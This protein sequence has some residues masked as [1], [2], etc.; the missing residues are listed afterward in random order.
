MTSTVP[1]RG[2]RGTSV[3]LLLALVLTLTPVLFR[4]TTASAAT[5]T[6]GAASMQDYWDGRANWVYQRK[7]SD[8]DTGQ[9]ETY[10]GAH[11]TIVGRTWYLFD[12]VNYVGRSNCAFNAPGTFNGKPIGIQVRS[13]INQGATWSAPTNIITPDAG[14]PWSCYATDGDAYYN[15]AEGTNGTWHYLFQCLPNTSPP[16]PWRGC[17]V[18]RSG[19]SPMGAFTTPAGATN[20]VINS[21]DIW[22]Q[23]CKAARTNDFCVKDATGSVSQEGTFQ[24]IKFDGTYY[25]VGFHG[26]DA[27]SPIKGFRGIA[28]TKDFVTFVS[29]NSDGLHDTPTDAALSAADA[30]STAAG[31]TGAARAWHEDLINGAQGAGDAA[32]IQEGNYYYQMTEEPDANFAGQAGQNWDY[33]I[34]R[35]SSLT[36]TST[37]WEPFPRGNPIEFSSTTTEIGQSAPLYLGLQYQRIFKDPA[38]GFTYLTFGRYTTDNNYSALYFYRL[39]KSTN[40]LANG[41]FGRADAWPWQVSPALS[42]STVM[43]VRRD[44]NG[45][46]NGGQYLDL[47]CASSCVAGQGIYQDVD[48]S[49][50]AGQRRMFTGKATIAT[51]SGTAFPTV[52]AT[53]YDASGA[54]VGTTSAATMSATTSYTTRNL[55]GKLAAT[56]TRVRFAV[57]VDPSSNKSYRLADLSLAI[58]GGVSTNWPGADPGNIARYARVSAS[59]S[60]S[61][62]FLP[63]NAR[64]G[65]FG[66]PNQNEWASGRHDRRPWIKYT[67]TAPQIV[68]SALIVDRSGAANANGG[69]LTFS[70]GSTVAVS[71]I[72]PNGTPL[73]VHF[74][75]RATTSVTFQVV[76]GSGPDVGLAELEV[77][78]APSS[79]M[80]D[81]NLAQSTSSVTA[82]S[83]YSSAFQ[84]GNVT[85]GRAYI[86]NIGEWASLGERNP[87]ITLH[88]AT[89]IAVN[90]VRLFDRS[91]DDNANGG[92]LTF[93]NGRT[94]T[95]VSVSGIPANGQPRDVTFPEKAG[96]TTIKFQVAGGS[97]PNVGLAEM[98]V[99]DGPMAR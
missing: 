88:W 80:G 46:P 70:D 63:T 52:T 68:T 21:G 28:K 42:G 17:T 49:A 3:L 60:L 38:T 76:D 10:T 30:P 20:P 73:T 25:W 22:S 43:T 51:D 32:V 79:Q 89:P 26:V 85:D 66:V 40:L 8:T 82:S 61:P 59:S 19:A 4:S 29:G 44:P 96:I 14:T 64:D 5:G 92:T 90:E 41:D 84:P 98:S 86:G 94:S 50:F 12:R 24:I 87:W 56:T 31:Q 72:P 55:S 39:E 6:G 99:W 35:A 71:N 36:A 83:Q 91:G 69:R 77:H 9:S 1:A 54:R 27:S 67:W 53:Q 33:G 16:G 62:A 95:T 11:V 78:G 74:T 37:Q 45:S 23:I 75:A 93:S 57:T 34:Y 18:S 97:G 48:V 65:L 7:L 15:A 2:L 47:G 81:G 58:S 13:S